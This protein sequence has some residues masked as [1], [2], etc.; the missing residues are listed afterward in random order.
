MTAPKGEKQRYRSLPA[1]NWSATIEKR[2]IKKK[3]KRDTSLRSLLEL[4]IVATKFLIDGTLFRVRK[5][6]RALRERRPEKPPTA[7]PGIRLTY[8]IRTQEKSKMFQGS[9]KKFPEVKGQILNLL[10]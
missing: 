8:P 6:R 10:G 4:N 2:K 7:P 1:K 9:S 3:I 5:G